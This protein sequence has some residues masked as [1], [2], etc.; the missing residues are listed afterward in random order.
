MLLLIHHGV[1]VAC[2]GF[3]ETAVQAQSCRAANSARVFLTWHPAAVSCFWTSPLLLLWARLCSSALNWL[4]RSWTHRLTL[5]N[6]ILSPSPCLSQMCGLALRSAP[7]SVPLMIRV[8]MLHIPNFM[9][10]K[11]T[12]QCSR[13][14]LI[15]SFLSLLCCLLAPHLSPWFSLLEIACLPHP[16][17]LMHSVGAVSMQLLLASLDQAILFMLLSV[18]FQCFCGF[19][20]LSLYLLCKVKS[21][22]L[23]TLLQL[24]QRQSLVCVV[25]GSQH[26]DLQKKYRRK[27]S[28]WSVFLSYF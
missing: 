5:R 3:P 4:V 2:F 27:G 11:S 1:C 9:S 18:S 14:C 26:R 16:P 17:R 8:S 25:P 22:F 23:L 15:P 19:L 20:R 12:L 13:P 24:T 7:R 6:T 21:T 10:L 28:G